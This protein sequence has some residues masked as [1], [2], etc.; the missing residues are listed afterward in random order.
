MVAVHRIGLLDPRPL[1]M[2]V[3]TVIPVIVRISALN[4]DPR[5]PSVS[6][7]RRLCLNS[8]VP[9][10][11]ISNQRRVISRLVIGLREHFGGT[12]YELV[13]GGQTQPDIIRVGRGRRREGSGRSSRTQRRHTQP[14]RR[15]ELMVWVMVGNRWETAELSVCTVGR[16]L[17]L[18]VAVV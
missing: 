2:T 10:I 13:E 18:D 9:V 14:I 15:R 6:E 1:E 4:A 16:V 7:R 3:V 5:R 12:G 11:V 17:V 8:P